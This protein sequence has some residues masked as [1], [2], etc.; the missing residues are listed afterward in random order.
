MVSA[1]TV[2]ICYNLLNI[3]NQ[4]IRSNKM[5][6]VSSNS[7]IDLYV[8]LDDNLAKQ[9]KTGRPALLSESELLAILIQSALTENHQCLQGIYDW[10]S[11]QHPRWFV[12]PNYTNFVAATP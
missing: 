12:L 5:K 7:I 8:C 2:L 3:K 11:R 4:Q 1:K 9:A 6:T 10:A